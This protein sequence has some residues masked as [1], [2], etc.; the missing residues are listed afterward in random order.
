M[1]EFPFLSANQVRAIA[2]LL[3][4]R[5]VLAAAREVGVNESTIRRWLGK[6]PAFQAAWKEARSG[7][8][9]EAVARAQQT[10]GEAMVVLRE[11]LMHAELDSNRVA[12]A[13]TILEV[14]LKALERDELR[15][16]VATI[17]RELDELR[18]HRPWSPAAVNGH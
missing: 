12:A 4:Q 15:E 17:R 3:T 13:R 10:A 16:Q 2:A 1:P 8:M 18:S 7:L 9:D 5:T 6:D 14:G 11:I